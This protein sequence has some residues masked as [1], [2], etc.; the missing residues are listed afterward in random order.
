MVISF[1]WGAIVFPDD[2]PIK[3]VPFAIVALVLMLV[4]LSGLGLS[5]TEF[6][7]NLGKI[8]NQTPKKNKRDF[9]ESIDEKSPLLMRP[10]ERKQTPIRKFLGVICALVAGT[11]NGSLMVPLKK[12]PGDIQGLCYMVSFGIGVV[13]VTTTFAIIYF[14]VQYIVW[15]HKPKFHI[16]YTF[17]PAF[18]SGILTTMGNICG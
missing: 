18:F 6:I 2:N 7:Q 15:K 17:L 9:Y 12:A 10:E 16:K 14:L 1:L 4:G 11:L 8:R 3:N 13:S 5:R